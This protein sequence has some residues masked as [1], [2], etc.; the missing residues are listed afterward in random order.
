MYIQ[1]SP[2]PLVRSCKDRVTYLC[3]CPPLNLVEG[4]SMGSSSLSSESW[5]ARMGGPP[6]TPAPCWGPSGTSSPAGSPLLQPP[7]VS[8]MPSG[9]LLWGA[10]GAPLAP[11]D[12]ASAGAPPLSVL[13][14]AS[15]CRA[16]P[17]PGAGWL[18]VRGSEATRA[19]ED[20][21]WNHTLLLFWW[22]L[23]GDHL[24][25]NQKVMKEA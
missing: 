24:F 16:D 7:D 25:N 9:S 5:F 6:G 20:R 23:A 18:W 13:A 8:S 19:V 2:V 17:G 1:H 11:W 3:P 22:Q 14:G 15:G 12:E 21:G 10:S 4:M